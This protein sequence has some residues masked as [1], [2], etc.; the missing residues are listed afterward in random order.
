MARQ[1]LALIRATDQQA[2]NI[3]GHT[4]LM[5]ALDQKFTG[6]RCLLGWL[7]DDRVTSDQCRDDMTIG[8]MGGEVE[9]AKHGKHAMRL[10][11]Q[12]ILFA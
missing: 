1:F 10:V 4:G 2:D 3:F 12:R 7:E 9:R 6:R 8:Q 11:A 5:I